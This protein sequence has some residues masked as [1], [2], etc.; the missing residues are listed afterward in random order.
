MLLSFSYAISRWILD[1]AVATASIRQRN[2][3]N[4]VAHIFLQANICGWTSWFIIHVLEHAWIGLIIV[5]SEVLR[6]CYRRSKGRRVKPSDGRVWEYN[7][8]GVGPERLTLAYYTNKG[9]SQLSY[10]ASLLRSQ[11]YLLK[12]PDAG[13]ASVMVRLTRESLQSAGNCLIPLVEASEA[14]GIRA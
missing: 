4:S 2:P 6:F 11:L 12:L 3:E 1:L 9:Q 10:Y 8:K 14:E 13:L 5:L 7:Q